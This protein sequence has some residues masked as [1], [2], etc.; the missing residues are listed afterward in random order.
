MSKKQTNKKLEHDNICEHCGKPAT[1]SI[2]NTW[3]EYAIDNAGKFTETNSWEG[4]GTIML[5]D[6]C[7]ID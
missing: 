3:T 1:R 6:D 2:E 4:S 7:K 5:C